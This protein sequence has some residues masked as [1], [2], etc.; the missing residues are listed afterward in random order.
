MIEHKHLISIINIADSV[1]KTCN[2][3]TFKWSTYRTAASQIIVSCNLLAISYSALF[4]SSKNPNLEPSYDKLNLHVNYRQNRCTT[5]DDCALIC[6]LNVAMT[7]FQYRAFTCTCRSA[8]NRRIIYAYFMPTSQYNI[9]KTKAKITNAAP[10][11]VRKTILYL[12]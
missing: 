1:C 12:C 4:T 5:K 8:H 3:A 10:E 11:D 9:S 6:S 2:Y 7:T